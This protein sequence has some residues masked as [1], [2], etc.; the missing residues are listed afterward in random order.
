MSE[1]R[2][3]TLHSICATPSINPQSFTHEKCKDL[4]AGNHSFVSRGLEKR[5]REKVCEAWLALSGGGGGER[6]VARSQSGVR[7]R[8]QQSARVRVSPILP[9]AFVQS[10]T[11]FRPVN[12]L[13][14]AALCFGAA[15]AQRTSAARH[16]GAPAGFTSGSHSAADYRRLRLTPYHGH[17]H[18]GIDQV[19]HGHG[20]NRVHGYRSKIAF[21][22]AHKSSSVFFRTSMQ[23]QKSVAITLCSIW[24]HI[25]FQT[26]SNWQL[27]FST[28]T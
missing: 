13:A 12:I 6:R 21:L 9:S 1:K 5:A 25:H 14:L 8:L 4:Q 24:W 15:V 28:W 2:G 26:L 16:V 23:F 17:G 11:M 7:R 18:H 10:A 22:F 27:H 20:T 19:Y 3:V